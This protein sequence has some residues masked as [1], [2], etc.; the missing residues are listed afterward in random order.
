MAQRRAAK[1]VTGRYYNTSSV[2]DMLHSLDWRTLE[3]RHVDSKLCMLYKIR[4]NLVAIR[5]RQLFTKRHR[6]KITSISSEQSRRGLY[7]FFLLSPGHHTVESTP[8]SDMLGNLARSLQNQCCEGRALQAQ[9]ILKI[10]SISLPFSLSLFFLLSFLI[11]THLFHS[12]LFPPS[13]TQLVIIF[14]AEGIP[15]S[16]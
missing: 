14:K 5:G 8:Q 3:Q 11:P 2:T 7:S 9:L 1:C 12:S 15:V 13:R 16:W 6:E 10:S 4:N